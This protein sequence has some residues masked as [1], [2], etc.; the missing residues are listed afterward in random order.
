MKIALYGRLVHKEYSFLRKLIKEMKAYNIELMAHQSIIE[1]L[2]KKQ[3]LDFPIESFN[4][5]D[6]LKD[7]DYLFSIGGDGTLLDAISYICKSQTPV[8]GINTGRLGF[9]SSV[10]DTEIKTALEAIQNKDYDLDS[11]TLISLETPNNPFGETNFAL[12]EFAVYRQE[13]GAMITT[14]VY[15]DTKHLNS[16]RADGVIISTPTGS[17]AYSLSCG[18]PI[19]MPNTENFII[20]PIAPHNLNVRPI[21]IK[22][23]QEITLKVEGRSKHFLLSLDSRSRIMPLSSVLKIKKS[24]FK[25]NL[26][27]LKGQDFLTTL[28]SKLMWGQDTRNG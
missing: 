24:D 23:S 5:S 27:R 22:D 21:V 20:T 13:S 3:K 15:L 7:I 9:L 26:V 11:R 1:Q 28:K 14:H 6:K 2:K 8:L 16:Y 4:D 19:M 10:S 12:N 17:T 18:G 25:V